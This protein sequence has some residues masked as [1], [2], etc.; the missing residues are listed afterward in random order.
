MQHGDAAQEFLLNRGA[1]RVREID[2]NELVGSLAARLAPGGR[3]RNE[4][5]GKYG[6]ETTHELLHGFPSLGPA[7]ATPSGSA[8]KG[9]AVRAANP[10]GP[11][12]FF[13]DRSRC[14]P[15]TLTLVDSA[16]SF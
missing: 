2:L 9:R 5:D 11:G 10:E 6:C 13:R 7:T 1:A 4:R 12:D 14:C 16:M 3:C 8:W 15:A